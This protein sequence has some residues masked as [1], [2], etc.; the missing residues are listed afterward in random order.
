MDTYTHT[1]LRIH[2]Q[3]CFSCLAGVT[4]RGR[5]HTA[6][7]FAA[8]CGR[9]PASLWVSTRRLR[10]K[11][12]MGHVVPPLPG[13]PPVDVPSESPGHVQGILHQTTLSEEELGMEN[14][15]SV[16]SVYLITF[17]ALARTATDPRG[18]TCPS[19]WAREDIA[20]V[21]LDAFR[22]PVHAH[23]G[24][25]SWGSQLQLK[26]FVVFREKHAP[27]AGE[28]SGPVHY[29]VAVKASGSFRWAPYKRALSVNHKLAT[30]WSCTHTGYWS[31]VRYGCM[32]TL[33][34]PQA[35]LD[36]TPYMWNHDGPHPPLFDVCQQPNTASALATRRERKVMAASESGP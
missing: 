9:M 13:M 18:H 23:S 7:H 35:D 8:V 26:S 17:P 16:K 15:S 20:R 4:D 21:I 19:Q 11:T 33:K 32:P 2:V 25:Q 3:V 31:A 30:H 12:S 24:N 14:G 1:H 6:V 29:H 5:H 10:Q 28:D 27:R 34:K 22:N 36:P